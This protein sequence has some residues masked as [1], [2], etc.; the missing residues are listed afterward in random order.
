MLTQFLRYQGEA[1]SVL[2]TG[3]SGF[4]GK[5]L[6][7]ILLGLNHRVTLLSRNVP[8][9]A[10]RFGDAVQFVTDLSAIEAAAR[11]EV[12]I[13]LAGEPL[14]GQRWTAQRKGRFLQSRLAVTAALC[15][16]IERLGRKPDVLING[17]AIGFYGPHGSEPL[18]EAGAAVPS[19]SH[20]LCR[21]WEEAA[22]KAERLGVRVCLLRIGIVL[23]PDGG[24]L[25]ELRRPF[26][27]GVAM[28]IADG[29]Q[30][31]SWIHLDDVVAIILYV[32]RNRAISGAVNTVA[33]HPVSNAEFAYALSAYLRTYAKVR[34]PAWLL[35]LVVGE[36]ADEVLVTGQRVIP[37]KLQGAGFEFMHPTLPL[38]LEDLIGPPIS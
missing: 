32:V 27:C 3:G 8:R 1:R 34:V 12:I 2:V 38:A 13:N 20:E 31:M 6:V 18:D 28:Q 10:Q 29:R 17:S 26:D 23:G 37:A 9:D 36:M 21:R 19:F 5:R 16:L 4:I 14:A 30:W 11:F 33:P 22:L 7:P 25:A 24:P 15:Q 35:R